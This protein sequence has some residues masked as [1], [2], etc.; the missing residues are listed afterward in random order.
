MIDYIVYYKINEVESDRVIT[1]EQY[2]GNTKLLEELLL[3]ELREYFE[4]NDI[5]LISYESLVDRE[6][7]IENIE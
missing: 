4:V 2:V 3:E 6:V 5:E 1:L 7:D